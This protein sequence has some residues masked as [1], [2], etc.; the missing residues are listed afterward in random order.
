MPELTEIMGIGK[1]KA[2]NLLNELQKMGYI[3]Q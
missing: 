1:D 2:N 3:Q